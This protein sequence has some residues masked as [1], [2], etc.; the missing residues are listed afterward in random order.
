M[1]ETLPQ[2][3]R[4]D[5]LPFGTRGGVLFRHEFP[6]NGE[7]EFRIQLMCRLGGECDGSVGFPD[8]HHLQVLVDGARVRSFSSAAAS[9]CRMRSR[10]RLR[11]SPIA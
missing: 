10:Q 6:R 2:Y 7:Y 11:A 8:E 4:M 3:D 5:G 1:P 9:I